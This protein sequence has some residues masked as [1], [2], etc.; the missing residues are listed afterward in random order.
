[1]KAVFADTFFFLASINPADAAHRRALTFSNNYNGPLITTAWVVTEIA[2]ALAHRENRR[3]FQNLY[4]AIS[5]DPRIDIIAPDPDLYDRGL[6][7]FFERSDKNW[8][9]TDCIS[10]VVMKDR[11]ISEAAT[12]DHHFVQ[13]GFQLAL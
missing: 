6:A 13:A 5:T 11:G 10:F 2:D 8:S 1:V 12:G 3:V 7:L 9:L 4:S